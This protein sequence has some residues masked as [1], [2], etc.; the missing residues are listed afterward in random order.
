VYSEHT[1]LWAAR[2]ERPT[3]NGQGSAFVPLETFRLARV[4]ENHW[5]KRTPGD[6][7]AS[8][9]TRLLVERTPVRYVIVPCGR[10]AHYGPLA[11]AFGSSRVFELA[12]E[13]ADG[14]RVYALRRDVPLP[15][16]GEGREQPGEVAGEDRE[17]VGHQQ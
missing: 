11:R 14:D 17:A 1:L 16:A 7:D 4:V 10:N 9:P 12:G 13:A 3:L 2:D 8:R 15:D 5:V 6:V